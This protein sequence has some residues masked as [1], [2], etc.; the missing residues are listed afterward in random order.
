MRWR[1]IPNNARERL[2]EYYV[3]FSTRVQ[4]FP[5]PLASE[6]RFIPGSLNPII[7]FRAIPDKRGGSLLITWSAIARNFRAI[8]KSRLSPRKGA[9]RLAGGY[10]T[11][12]PVLATA[13]GEE[14]QAASEW[15]LVSGDREVK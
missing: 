6:S 3:Q 8:P 4:I 1:F 12:A 7:A 11:L 15:T 13:T 14:T 9:T 5:L 2:Y 10:V